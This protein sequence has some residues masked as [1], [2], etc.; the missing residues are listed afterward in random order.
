LKDFAR[1]DPIQPLVSSPGASQ[2]FL[3]QEDSPQLGTGVSVI[4]PDTAGAVGLGQ[5]VRHAKQQLPSAGQSNWIDSFHGF[6]QYVLVIDRGHKRILLTSSVRSLPTTA[7][8]LF[9][10][11]AV[12]VALWVSRPKNTAR[13][14][15]RT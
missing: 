6:N 1:S 10:A 5:I 9:L 14:E 8:S 4:P 7:G 13:K 12:R 11:L 2:S 15:F 3:A